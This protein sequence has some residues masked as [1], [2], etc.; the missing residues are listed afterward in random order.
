MDDGYVVQNLGEPWTFAGARLF[1]W[2]CGL[3]VGFIAQE[4]FLP[5]L[6]S[7]MPIFLGLI[8]GTTLLMVQLRKNYPDEE[9]GLMNHLISSLGFLPPNIPAPANLQPLWSGAPMREL[10]PKREFIELGLMEVDFQSPLTEE[11]QLYKN[12]IG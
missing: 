11:D 2:T 12:T 7:S 3:A 1:E 8:I 6:G 5:N 9:R 10:D 4:M